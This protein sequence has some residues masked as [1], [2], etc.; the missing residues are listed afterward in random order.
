MTLWDRAASL[1]GTV[2]DRRPELV[3]LPPEPPDFAT[4]FTFM[5]DAEL[6]FSSLRMR[7]EE[8]TWGARGEQTLLHDVLIRHPGEARVTSSEPD[9]GTR[10]NY[11]VW[12]SD[13]TTVR[14]YSGIHRIATTRPVRATL[15]G[16]DNPDLPASSRVYHALTSLPMESLPELFVHPAGYLQNVI[17]TGVPTIVTTAVHLG[18]EA[19]V[20]H[21]DH[22]RVTEVWND[23][24]DYAVELTVDRETGAILRLVESVGEDVTRDAVVTLFD[25]DPAL[26]PAAFEFK[27]PP[28]ATI[29]Y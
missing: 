4:L 23:R 29:L 8:R 11:E 7:I 5:R 14:S 17:A 2:P 3:A 22:P 21:S 27:V 28:G 24:P 20:I 18:R 16:V 25:V 12:L 9:L 10:G 19:I 26:P 1:P 6:R 15:V 13:G